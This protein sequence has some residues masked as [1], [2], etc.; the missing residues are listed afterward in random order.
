MAWRIT[1]W[2]WQE[3]RIGFI[4]VA[5]FSRRD[6]EKTSPGTLQ[7]AVQL[8]QVAFQVSPTAEFAWVDTAQY[9]PYQD[10]KGNRWGKN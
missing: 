8:L 1:A 10:P 5:I 3:T 7:A 4:I 6:E 2:E 9:Q